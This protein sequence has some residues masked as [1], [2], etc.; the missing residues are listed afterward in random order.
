MHTVIHILIHRG[1]CDS[2]EKGQSKVSLRSTCL[3]LVAIS[4]QEKSVVILFSASAA[5]VPAVPTQFS[6]NVNM[7][8][9]FFFNFS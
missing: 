1:V 2:I 4:I 5:T 7:R 8:K 6:L 3:C 9:S